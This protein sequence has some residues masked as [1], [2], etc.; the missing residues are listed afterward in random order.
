[1]EA[2]KIVLNGS[3]KILDMALNSLLKNMISGDSALC[4]PRS[5]A[6]RADRAAHKG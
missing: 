2:L 5:T 3:R 4:Y 6:M 1:M